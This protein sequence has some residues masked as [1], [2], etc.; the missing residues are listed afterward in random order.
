MG[1]P[2]RI[3]QEAFD[4]AVAE[5]VEEFGMTPEEALAEAVAGLQLQGVDLSNV[6]VSLP[7]EGGRRQLR[8]VAAT[9][10]L[11]AAQAAAGDGVRAALA[12]LAAELVGPDV[13]PD[14]VQA[15]GAAWRGACAPSRRALTAALPTPPASQAAPAP[16]TRCCRRCAASP[17]TAPQARQGCCRR[18]PR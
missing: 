16:W 9:Q 1:P 12:A 14:A 5:N 17:Q 2:R 13:E 18:W 8:A 3:T 4:A 15:A 7:E 6:R 11:V 10:A